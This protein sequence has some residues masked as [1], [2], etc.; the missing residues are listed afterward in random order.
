MRSFGTGLHGFADEALLNQRA[1]EVYA[2]AMPAHEIVPIPCDD[3][4]FVM[5]GLHCATG[6]LPQP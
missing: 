6:T 1:L 5:G 3:L 2:Q 4:T